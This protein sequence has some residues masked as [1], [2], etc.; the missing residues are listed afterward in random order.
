MKTIP[1]ALQAHKAQPLTTLCD[2]VRI[3]PLPDDSIIGITSLSVDVTY[4]DGDGAVT[5]YAHTGFSGSTQTSTADLSVDNS[6]AQT[7][8]A[9]FTIPG[10][11]QDMV[12]RGLLD[13]VPFIAYRV[14]YEDLTD[15][16]EILGSGTLGEQTVKVGGLVVLE[17]RSISQQLRQSVV[18]LDS[19]TC[20]VK[21]FGSQ[22]GDERFHCGYDITGEW[23]TGTV[24]AA[25]DEPTR[26]FES[27]GF[28]QSEDYFAPGVVEM[29]TGDNAGAV[30]EVEAFEQIIGAS[31]VAEITSGITWTQSSAFSGLTANATNMRDG[32]RTTGGATTNANATEY[33][34]LDL[35][36]ARPISRIALA[37]GNLP[38]WGGVAAYLNGRPLQYS[39]DGTTGWTTVATVSGVNDTGTL[40]NFNFTE[41][42]A[43]YWR[44][45]RVF[46]YI[47][48]AEFRIYETTPGGVIG[49]RVTLQFTLPKPINPG[50]T[51]RIRRDCTRAWTGRNSCATYHGTSKGLHFRGEPYIPVADAVQVP[52]AE[53]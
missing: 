6:E 14:N 44:A 26:Q 30:I 38:G 20:R 24:S 18:E 40:F 27:S 10:V 31:T 50:D 47:A 51:F 1:I 29:L 9:E 41:A 2:L 21:R 45:S 3:G 46:N 28:T 42:S 49:G 5:Y 11:T 15:G 53:T 32:D 13:K 17:L 25:G 7:L 33:I 39:L 35:G 8:I 16:H 4:N 36:S 52:G 12:D 48:A 19:L 37:G 43:R 23:V 34:R 22:V